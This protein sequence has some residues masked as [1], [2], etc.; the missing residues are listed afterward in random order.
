MKTDLRGADLWGGGCS[1]VGWH[2]EDGKH[3][4][5]VFFP[6]Y[7]WLMRLLHLVIPSWAVCG[8]LL[9]GGCYV[10]ACCLFFRLTCRI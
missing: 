1:A 8:H 7:P 6:L 2:T 5:L 9:S 10:G 4:F 3:L